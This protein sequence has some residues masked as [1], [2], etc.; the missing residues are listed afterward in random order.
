MYGRWKEKK[1]P[2]GYVRETDLTKIKFPPVVFGC[3]RTA[4]WVMR[5]LTLWS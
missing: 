5:E 3:M 1:L 2:S 4:G